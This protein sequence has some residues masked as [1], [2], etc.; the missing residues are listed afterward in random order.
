[1]KKRGDSALFDVLLCLAEVCKAVFLLPLSAFFDLMSKRGQPYIISALSRIFKYFFS[2]RIQQIIEF[3][4][5][6][7]YIFVK[8]RT[9]YALISVFQGCE[10][11]SYQIEVNGSVFR[12]VKDKIC[13][14]PRSPILRRS[15][16]VLRFSGTAQKRRVAVDVDAGVFYNGIAEP[17]HMRE[18]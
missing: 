13:V 17:P 12:G 16:Q 8:K 15:H 14:L 3:F 6:T 2:F 11:K 18:L 10:S 7:A 9:M 5:V 1:M 4:Q